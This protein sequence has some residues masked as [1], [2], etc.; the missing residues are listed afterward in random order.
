MEFFSNHWG[1]LFS[2][3]G[4]VVSVIGLA[5]AILEAHGARSAAQ[6]AERATIETRNSVRRHLVATD[7][8]RASSHIRSLKLM[9]R[10]GRWEAALEQYQ[11]LTAI[12]SDIII[13][14]PGADSEIHR[15]LTQAKSSLYVMEYHVDQARVGGASGPDD[16]DRMNQDLNEILSDLDF[17]V[18]A[19]DFGEWADG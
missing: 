7:L 11:T 4:V 14:S 16:W 1:S 13:R 6:S 8:E 12:I 2:V 10:E 5:W 18:G 9:H 19:M 17:I 15:R 3:I